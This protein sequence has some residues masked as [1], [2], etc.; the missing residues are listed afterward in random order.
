MQCIRA[1]RD[2][3]SVSSG[4][5]PSLFEDSLITYFE[6]TFHRKSLF[7]RSFDAV[8]KSFVLP[9][10]AFLRRGSNPGKWLTKA[11]RRPRKSDKNNN[12]NNRHSAPILFSDS[13]A[14]TFQSNTYDDALSF[15]T[16]CDIFTTKRQ[17]VNQRRERR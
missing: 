2:Q 4:S 9:N 15:S 13:T 14:D 16:N 6:Q 5:S 8:R 3:S 1:N 12:N 10:Y 17:Q 11:Q 7:R